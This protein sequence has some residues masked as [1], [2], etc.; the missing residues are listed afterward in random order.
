MD[1]IID[2][3]LLAIQRATQ[4]MAPEQASQYFQNAADKGLIPGSLDYLMGLYRRAKAIQASPNPQQ[5]QQAANQPTVK[6]KLE[7]QLSSGLGAIPAPNLAGPDVFKAAAGG[8]V[9]FEDGGDVESD[10][11]WLS[12]NF[13][14]NDEYDKEDAALGGVDFTKMTPRQQADFATQQRFKRAFRKGP[15]AK[16][17]YLAREQIYNRSGLKGILDKQRKDYEGD[18]E[19]LGKE[20]E[21]AK[22]L[23]FLQA[24]SAMGSSA[25]PFLSAVSQSVAPA[26]AGYAKTKKELSGEQRKMREGLTGLDR[27]EAERKMGMQS[28]YLTDAG[29]DRKSKDAEYAEAFKGLQELGL[30]RE[31]AAARI[32]ASAAM[33]PWSAFEPIIMGHR[34]KL[35]SKLAEI[36]KLPEGSPRRGVLEQEAKQI[37]GQLDQTMA[38]Y[39]RAQPTLGGAGIRAAT[40]TGEQMDKMKIA[41]TRP[42]S[43]WAVLESQI[44]NIRDSGQNP[45][46]KEISKEEQAALITQMRS[47][48]SQ[49][50]A[51]YLGRFSA[52][53]GGEGGSKEVDFSS[54]D[55]Q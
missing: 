37:R 53:E 4:G 55:G 20:R 31:E 21:H 24:G 26:V 3:R 47:K 44:K 15:G 6:D 17:N 27:T 14:A 52:Y 10:M 18:V 16:E 51:D 35:E 50:E 38:L 49:L 22:A 29:A 54:L 32:K 23:A 34:A 48:Q 19:G 36:Q 42:G 11:P 45:Q 25:S 1:G 9:S 41:M 39:S 12:S 5:M 2:P 13:G 30:K 40:A 8:I 28:Q 43:P 7:G 33:S 46:G